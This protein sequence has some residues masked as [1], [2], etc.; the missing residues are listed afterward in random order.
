MFLRDAI[1]RTENDFP[2]HMIFI[3]FEVIYEAGKNIVL[4]EFADILH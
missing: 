1:V 2:I 4:L 3:S